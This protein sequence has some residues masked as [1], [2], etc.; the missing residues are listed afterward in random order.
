MTIMNV[1][2]TRL[3]VENIDTRS[4]DYRVSYTTLADNTTRVVNHLTY[5]DAIERAMLLRRR[6]YRASVTRMFF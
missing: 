4:C 3:T 1:T 2:S 6:G 5:A